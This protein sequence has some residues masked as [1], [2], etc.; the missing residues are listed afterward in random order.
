MDTKIAQKRVNDLAA[1]MVAKG[2][3]EPTASLDIRA[4]E[5][6][7][8]YLRWKNGI[9]R[10]RIFGDDS[11]EFIRG[12]VEAALDK[13]AAYIAKQPDAEQ[14]K[15]QD[16]LSA[17][18]SVIDIGKKHGIDADYLNP[19]VA[20]MKKLSENALTDQRAA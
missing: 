7:S 15:L 9:G 20:S 4:N 19:L 1:A 11:F 16:F 12:D 17:L 2:M 3:R 14:A 8:V 13:A 5:E 6:P 18:G 10:D